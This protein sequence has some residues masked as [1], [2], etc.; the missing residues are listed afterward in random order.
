MTAPAAEAGSIDAGDGGMPAT[1][2]NAYIVGGGIA[3]LAAAALLIRDGRMPGRNIHVL[4]QSDRPGGSL[5]GAGDPDSGYVIRGGRMFEAHFGCTFDLLG[6]IPSLADPAVSVSEELHAFTEQVVTSSNCR[7]VL[8]GERVEAPPL[9][10]SLRDKWDLARLALLPE[11]VLGAR[12]I[13]GYF[14]PGFFETNFWIMWCTMFAFQ[15]W[16]SLIEFRR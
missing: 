10:L 6:T 5:D 9:N 4:E 7:I 11:L 16:H 8:D 14:H 15:P 12:T 1:E 2:R 3:G 13:E